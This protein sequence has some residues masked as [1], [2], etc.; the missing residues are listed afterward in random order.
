MVKRQIT[1]RENK[2]LIRWVLIGV[3]S[4]FLYGYF[5]RKL[6]GLFP[7]DE[8]QLFIGIGLLLIAAYFFNLTK[9]DG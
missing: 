5:N 4:F 9:Y 2:Q 8:I 7:E 1:M 6:T 3:G